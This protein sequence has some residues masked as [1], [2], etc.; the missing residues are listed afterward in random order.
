VADRLRR[1]V[2]MRHT[3]CCDGG[4]APRR[5]SRR[6]RQDQRRITGRRSRRISGTR[7]G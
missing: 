6:A 2:E 4:L 3:A 5:R 7:T 1:A